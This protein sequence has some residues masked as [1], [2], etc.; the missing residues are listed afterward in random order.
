AV[1]KPWLGRHQIYAIF[2]LPE[3]HRLRTPVLL[4]VK[5]VGRY[6]R[7]GLLLQRLKRQPYGIEPGYYAVRVY[8]R[9]RLGWFLWLRGL[10]GQ[11]QDSRNWSLSYTLSDR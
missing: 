11:L 9:T 8:L 2:A 7:E 6:R 3:Q 5:G 10:F 1:A 4:T